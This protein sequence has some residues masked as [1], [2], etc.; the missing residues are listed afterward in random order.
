MSERNDY[1]IMAMKVQDCLYKLNQT[2]M[3]LDDIKHDAAADGMLRT[4]QDIA[5]VIPYLMSQ[6]DP[7]GDIVDRLNTQ[8]EDP[9]FD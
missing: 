5:L 1:A 3:Q 7:L 8:A 4:E 6:R 9:D 2:I